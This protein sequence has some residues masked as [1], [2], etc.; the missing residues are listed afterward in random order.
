MYFITRSASLFVLIRTWLWK[1]NPVCRQ[2][3]RRSAHSGL[4][5]SLW[6][7][8]TFSPRPSILNPQA[9]KNFLPFLNLELIWKFG[10]KG[11]CGD[12]TLA[13]PPAIEGKQLE[14]KES[15]EMEQKANR[16]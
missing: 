14:S 8:M 16:E 15:R 12:L 7:D 3:R 5:I 10:I 9:Q 13:G 11:D 4:R 1:L 2:E 6:T